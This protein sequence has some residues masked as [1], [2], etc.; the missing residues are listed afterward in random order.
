MSNQLFSGEKR[1]KQKKKTN[2][3]ELLFFLNAGAQKPKVPPI[4]RP[5][6]K[7]IY[8]GLLCGWGWDSRTIDSGQL[9]P[10][11][12]TPGQ[13]TPGQLILDTITN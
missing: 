10:G 9:T 1:E 13:L 2:R 12:L 6:D 3:I 4:I 11:Q 5:D 8:W 7:D